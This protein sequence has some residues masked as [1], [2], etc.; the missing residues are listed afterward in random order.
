[1]EWGEQ[2]VRRSQRALVALSPWTWSRG[3]PVDATALAGG[4]LEPAPSPANSLLSVLLGTTA[5]QEREA[6]LRSAARDRCEGS[7]WE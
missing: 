5:Q 3:A 1:M 4:S 6:E 2:G 7:C